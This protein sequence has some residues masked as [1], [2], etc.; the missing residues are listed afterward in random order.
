MHAGS[1]FFNFLPF[2]AFRLKL[3]IFAAYRF[4]YYEEEASPIFGELSD[5]SVPSGYV[6]AICV[7]IGT[8][9]TFDERRISSSF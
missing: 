8:R 1:T 4:L 3:G 5:C 7:M 2:E 9:S 6:G